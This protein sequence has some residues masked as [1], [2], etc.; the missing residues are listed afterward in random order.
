MLC[1]FNAFM[2]FHSSRRRRRWQHSRHIQK[3]NRSNENLPTKQI[4]GSERVNGLWQCIM[5]R[6]KRSLVEFVVDLYGRAA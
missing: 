3:L 5:A 6:T 4:S 2:P 1:Y